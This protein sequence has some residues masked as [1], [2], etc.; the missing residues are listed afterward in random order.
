VQALP[1]GRLA[2]LNY[3][4]PRS[5]L[6]ALPHG[7]AVRR[8]TWLVLDAGT[9]RDEAAGR[10]RCVEGIEPGTAGHIRTRALGDPDVFVPAD[11]RAASG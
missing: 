10:L 2:R 9:D 4:A 7:A 11:P 6:P 3:S 1:A 8:R 5:T